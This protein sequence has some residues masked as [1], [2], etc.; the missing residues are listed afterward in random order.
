MSRSRFRPSI[1]PRRA[2]SFRKVST[3]GS[4]GA[5]G[6]RTPT[7]A[8]FAAGCAVATSGAKTRSAPAKAAVMCRSVRAMVGRSPR[9]QASFDHLVGAG[10]Q[11]RWEVKPE[12]L[13]R[14]QVDDQLELRRLSNRKVPRSGPL[15]DFVHVFDSLTIAVGHISPVG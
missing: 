9:G 12:C 15:Q 2:S 6:L 1:H 11:G 5:N 14:P 13:R 3:P 7:L 10:E 8:R 4:W